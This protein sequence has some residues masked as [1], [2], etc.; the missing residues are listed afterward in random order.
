MSVVQ[1]SFLGSMLLVTPLGVAPVAAAGSGDIDQC[2][3]DPAPSPPSNGCATSSSDWVNGN[4]NSSKSVFLEGDSIPYRIK[5]DGLATSGSNTVT[6][7]W[8]TTKG[9][10]HAIDYITTWNRSVLDANPCLGVAGCALGSFTTF[11]I[12]VDPQ[13]GGAGVTQAAGVFTMFGGTITSVSAYSYSGGGGFT[14]DKMASITLTFTASVANPVL[15]WGGHIATRADWGLNNSAVAITGSPYHTRILE[16]NGSGGNQD[17]SLKEDAVIFPG[18]ITIIKQAT[19]E[20]STSF[21]FTASPSPL[22]NFSLVDDGT[23]ANTKVF[24]NIVDFGTYTV[25]ETVPGGWTLTNRACV[26]TSA[27]GGST[28]NSGSF[29]RSINLA[30]GENVTCTFT[31]AEVPAPSL[32]ITKDASVPGGT[33][34]VAGEQISYVITVAN[35]GNVTLTNVVVTDPYADA[36]SIVRNATDVVGDE[37]N[38]LEVGETWGYTAVHTVTQ[39]ELDSNGGGNGLLE[40]TATADSSETGPDTDDANVPVGQAPSLNITK[41]ASVPG[42]TA[43]VA[44]EQISYVITVANTGNVTLTNVVVTDPYADAGSIVRNATDV[45]GDEDNLLEVGETWGYTA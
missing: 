31:N 38:L 30:E 1:A 8:D 29:G 28:S 33:A 23:A 39:A 7:E 41:D 21:P 22:S 16:V 4:L 42:G 6:I 5:L 43:N 40:N 20:G 10:K 15:A 18:S 45:V 11:P 17:R 37:D 27:N 14:G 12:P 2:A 36:G 3:N 19:P 25:T 26:V 44:G 24:S 35:T 13:V 34:N 9:G 32:N